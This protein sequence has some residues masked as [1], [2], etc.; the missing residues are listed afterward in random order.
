[1]PR[2][3]GG[4]SCQAGTSTVIPALP[5][6]LSQPIFRGI[7]TQVTS[8]DV[9]VSAPTGKSSAVGPYVSSFYLGGTVGG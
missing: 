6:N 4:C 1:V 7:L 8:G 5:R 3:A 2:Y 9:A